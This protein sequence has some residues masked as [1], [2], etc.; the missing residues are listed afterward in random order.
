[1]YFSLKGAH[2]QLLM[3][4]TVVENEGYYERRGGGGGL[5]QRAL[6][7][8]ANLKPRLSPHDIRTGKNNS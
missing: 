2:H 6:A 5:I 4:N 3:T 1:M 7:L 8:A